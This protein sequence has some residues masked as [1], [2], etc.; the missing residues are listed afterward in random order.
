MYFRPPCTPLLYSKTG[1]CR[2]IHYL[3]IVQ[4]F[5]IFKWSFVLNMIFAAFSLNKVYSHENCFKR[6]IIYTNYYSENSMVRR[7]MVLH[8]HVIVM[9]HRISNQLWQRFP[10]I[11]YKESKH[12]FILHLQ[13]KTALLWYTTYHMKCDSLLMTSSVCMWKLNDLQLLKRCTEWFTLNW[14]ILRTKN[15]AEIFPHLLLILSKTIRIF[16]SIIEQQLR[17]INT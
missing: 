15:T 11:N 4:I 10:F 14:Y 12:A 16:T 1:I 8:G 5:D 7:S 13:L 3:T 2:G 9:I 6:F 17:K